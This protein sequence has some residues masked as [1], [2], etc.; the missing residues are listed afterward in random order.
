MKRLI[1]GLALVVVLAGSGVAQTCTIRTYFGE[2]AASDTIKAAVIKEIAGART[3]LDIALHSFTDD[4]IGDAVVRAVRR[5]VIVRVI[6]GAGQDKMI[7]GEYDKL[8]AAGV[9]VVVV[10]SQ[11][12]FNHRFA[13]IDDQ[14]VI[15]GSYDWSDYSNKSRYDNVLLISCLV[16]N[17]TA[18]E[19]TAEFEQLWEK[20][21]AETGTV[22]T[23]T[24]LS[25]GVQSVVIHSVDPA[26][27]CIQLLDI[28]SAPIDIG[29]WRLSDLEGSYAFPP[30]TIISPN[31]PYE[32]C[33]DTYNPSYDPQGLF[34]NDEHDEVFL[35]TPDGRII[36]ERVWGD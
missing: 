17:S 12:L 4:Q 10:D 16:E 30:D 24:S 1:L 3:S 26:G 13:V 28:S 27:E 35:I 25:S 34:L 36:D 19:F 31:D 20:L 14:T 7:G 22:A 5:G 23:A 6:L 29:G 33:I 9:E 11:A 2:P 18:Q 15:T 8:V 21:G 32:V